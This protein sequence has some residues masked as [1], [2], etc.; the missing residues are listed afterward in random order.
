M[1]TKRFFIAA[2]AAA[3]SAPGPVFAQ[4]LPDGPGKETVAS[5]CGT[6]HDVNR[7]RPGY[8][9]EGWV[10]VINMM[11]N[12][13]TPVPADQWPVITTY[14]IK[15]FPERARPAAVI[16][17]GPAEATIKMWPV[18]TLGSRP[19]DPLATKDGAIWWTG[20]LANKLGRVDP[21]TNTIREYTLKSPHSGPHGLAEDKD[22]NI[23]FT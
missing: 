22:G 18:P 3:M 13:A 14:L 9:P 21:K 12:F 11:Q 6:C 16:I 19:H 5:V 4:N 15:N 20:Q 7:I 1:S 10:T 23:W 8:T 2:A 17:P